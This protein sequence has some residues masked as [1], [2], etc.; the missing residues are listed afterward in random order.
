VAILRQRLHQG[1][2]DCASETPNAKTP[3]RV[4]VDDAVQHVDVQT[5]SFFSTKQGHVK[6]D[7]VIVADG[8]YVRS[9]FMPCETRNV[10]EEKSKLIRS[11]AQDVPPLEGTTTAFRMDFDFAEVIKDD[12]LSQ[13]YKNQD[14]GF[15]VLKMEGSQTYILTVNADQ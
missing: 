8:C 14:F 10:N 9:T 2:L 1:I 4:H 6:K 5:G 15:V 12:V 3:I 11:I 7:V 13:I